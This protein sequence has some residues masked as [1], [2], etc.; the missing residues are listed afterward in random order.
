MI[1][2]VS[3]FRGPRDWRPQLLHLAAR[4]D[5]VAIE[6]RDPRE[7]ELPDVG[8]LWLVDPESGRQLRVDT[9][10]RKLRRAVRRRAAAADRDELARELRSLG[11]AAPDALDRRRL[12]PARSSASSRPKGGGDELRL[13]DRAAAGL[14][15]VALALIA[16][17]ARR[18]GGGAKYVVRFTNLA[19]LE[20]VVAESPRW[21]RHVPPALT[22][23]RPR[24]ARDPTSRGRE[25]ADGRPARR[26]R[27]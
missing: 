10:S 1:V 27:Q 3:D 9:R 11:V 4:H 7:Q 2:V 12:A 26:R 21:R 8:D 23:P 18:S 15:L 19:L 16:Y 25:I 6:I 20:N 13:A 24:R 22:L 5:V 14:V 17:I